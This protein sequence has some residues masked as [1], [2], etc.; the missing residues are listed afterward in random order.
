MTLTKDRM[1]HSI[2]RRLEIPKMQSAQL[3]DAFLE[4][5]K[6]TLENGEHMVISGFGK[7]LIKDKNDRRGR[8]PRNGNDP[9][10]GARRVVTFKSSP[11]LVNKVNKDGQ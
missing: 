1:I 9:M 6:K 7:F 10:L 4:I 8:N 2:Y 5:M 11:I 3:I